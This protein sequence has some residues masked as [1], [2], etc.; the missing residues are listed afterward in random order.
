MVEAQVTESLRLQ[1]VQVQIESVI[2]GKSEVVEQL[3]IGLLAQGHVLL[4]DV[5]GV[6][7][8]T[9]VKALSAS[10]SLQFS[11][12]Q[13]TPDL[14][15]QDLLGANIL[16]PKEGTFSFREGPVFT[17]LLLADEINRASPRTQSSLLEAMNEQQVTIDN[18]THQLSSPFM[19][20][21]TQNPVEFQGTYPLP[22]AQLDRFMMRL[23]LGYPTTTDEL[24]ILQDR[25]TEDPLSRVQA[26]LTPAALI[27]MQRG[28]CSVEVNPDVA[29]YILRLVARTRKMEA[30]EIGLSPRSA[31]ALYRAAQ[32]RA[33]LHR[34]E[35]V[36]PEDVQSLFMVCMT[37]R[38]V[39]SSAARYGGTT[40]E[41]LML[42]LLQ[43]E[44]LPL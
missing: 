36:S 2:K 26:V 17:H 27:E 14:L 10:L 25:R 35:Y 16:H 32:A 19:V 24:A 30:V 7:K 21:A 13:F 9:L 15:P 33:Y 37:H 42:N 5:P 3:L 8:T 23:S 18:T 22:E 12:I 41:Q 44:E 38:L 43:T 28:V 1:E 20:V 29:K 40:S 34:R 6:G 4:E 11:R 39:L 31:L